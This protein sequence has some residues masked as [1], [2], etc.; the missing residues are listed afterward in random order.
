MSVNMP[1]FLFTIINS[2]SDMVVYTKHV[3][4]VVCKRVHADTLQYLFTQQ[5]HIYTLR[6]STHIK[7]KNLI[8]HQKL[9][10]Y[11][12]PDDSLF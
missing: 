9:V 3:P 2:Y 12:Y 7:N 5:A 4:Y 10:L 6:L 8:Q 1:C 11:R